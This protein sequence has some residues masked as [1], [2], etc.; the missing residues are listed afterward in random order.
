M[1]QTRTTTLVDQWTERRKTS[2]ALYQRAERVFP[3]GVTHDIRYMQPFPIYVTHADG[4]RKWDA[5]GNE[6]IDYWMGHGALLLGHNYPVVRDATA[7]QALKGTHYGA[8]HELEVE[9]GELIQQ[10]VPS[11]EKV[12]FFSSGTEATQMALRLVRAFTGK[13]KILKMR[14]HFHGWHD[15]ATIGMGEPWD[16]PISRGV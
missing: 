11:G 7:E 4:S 10:I 3:S 6:Y 14:G 8:C 1:A 15:Y 2:A 12:K 9:W 5:D 13:E 16:E